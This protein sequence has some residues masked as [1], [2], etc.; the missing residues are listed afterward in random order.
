ME[1]ELND[2][3]CEEHVYKKVFNTYSEAINN[4]F[5]YKFGNREMAEESVQ[6]AF[7]K[8]WENCKKVPFSKAKSYLYTVANNMS[9]NRYKHQKVVL[10]YAKTVPQ[11]SEDLENP[12]YK[13]QEEQFKDKLQLAIQNLS[14]KQRTAFLLHRIDEKSYKEIAELLKISVKAVEKRMQSALENLRKNIEE[15]K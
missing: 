12:E 10:N 6:E 3:V 15:F 11:R 5:Y 7:I 9:I 4:Y 14:E 2:N 8:L 1:K 13:M